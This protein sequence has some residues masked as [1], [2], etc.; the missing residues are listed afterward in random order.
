M[1]THLTV[2]F[3]SLERFEGT[4]AIDLSGQLTVLVGANGSGKSTALEAVAEIMT[5]LQL[6]PIEGPAAEVMKLI[7]PHRPTNPTWTRATVACEFDS[8]T[9]PEIGDTLQSHFPPNNEGGG[10]A[11]VGV[12][13]RAGVDGRWTIDFVACNGGKVAFDTSG[14]IIVDSSRKREAEHFLGQMQEEDERVKAAADQSVSDLNRQI[15]Q[16]GSDRTKALQVNALRVKLETETAAPERH[17][18][19][20]ANRR[21]ELHDEIERSK[22][23]AMVVSTGGEVG[24]GD[25][26]ALRKSLGLPKVVYLHGLPDFNATIGQMTTKLGRYHVEPRPERPES[27]YIAMRNR[28]H[29][30]LKMDIAVD[31]TDRAAHV[32]LIDDRKI[33]E[34]SAG[35]WYALGFASI[36][37]Q[38]DENTLV[39]WDEP[40]TGLHTTWAR[41]ICDLMLRDLRRFL[42][43]THRTEFVPPSTATGRIYK[44]VAR[45]PEPGKKSICTFQEA[46]TL[47]HRFSIANALG[48]EPSRILFTANAV[49]WVEGPSDLIY[50][51]FWLRSAAEKKQIELVEGF[52]YCFMFTGGTLLASETIADDTAALPPDTVN[53]LRLVGTSLVIV[54]TDF[55]PDDEPTGTRRIMNADLEKILSTSTWEKYGFVTEECRRH[56]KPR[57]KALASAID[58]L[59]ASDNLSSLFSTWGREAENGLTDDAFRGTLKGLYDIADDSAA[60]KEIER[61][62]VNDWRS[63]EL[64]IETALAASVGKS[65]LQPLWTRGKKGQLCVAQMSIIRNKTRFAQA[66]V[67]TQKHVGLSSLRP[68]AYRIV[69]STLAWILSVKASYLQ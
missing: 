37:E 18:Q 56:L 64:E 35:T 39:I 60:A 8:N 51:R 67:D 34:V 19:Q 55:N 52:D 6:Y 46:T 25:I 68:E 11:A 28:L 38:A 58:K 26:E 4:V 53:L 10:S 27:P 45:P 22:G 59:R 57:V 47:L 40:E 48:M 20:T 31:S 1:L 16:L 49:I 43:A 50:W 2:T 33:E 5:F 12:T 63:Y 24:K 9:R 32:L 65:D 17:R 14:P 21:K 41:K 15:S 42:I 61:V 3:D 7:R 29:E 23:S 54:D 66:Y 13:K 69:E 44:T 36:C 30:L 62:K